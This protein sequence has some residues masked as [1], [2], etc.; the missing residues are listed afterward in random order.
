MHLWSCTVGTRP[1]VLG[2]LYAFFLSC[3]CLSFPYA[4]LKI[5]LVS[6]INLRLVQCKVDSVAALAQV[7]P[8]YFLALYA[9]ILSV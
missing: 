1:R 7:T 4:F 8:G 5:K 9:L 3:Y 6:T 2:L